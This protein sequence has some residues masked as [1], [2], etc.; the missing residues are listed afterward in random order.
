M[1][2]DF[3]LVRWGDGRTQFHQTRINSR[4]KKY[5][6]QFTLTRGDTVLVP[7][8][9]K[10]LDMLMLQEQGFNVV[11]VELS[12]V[13]AKAF[14]NE[15]QLSY[16]VSKNGN[17]QEFTGTGNAIG[18]RLLVGDFFDV[19]AAEI[20]AISAFYDRA[21]LIAL[22]PEMRRQYAVK[23]AEL[24]PAGASGLLISLT[25]DPSKM[26]GP[27]F[28]VPHEEVVELFSARFNITE[29]ENYS[30][31]ERLGSLAQR[32]LDTM[33]ERVYQLERNESLA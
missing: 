25:Y 18:I 24:V 21:S 23:M 6:P 16:E 10:S 29:L 26:N 11:G 27:P 15:N 2:A 31:H 14:F 7:L 33:E 3:W 9:G 4:L 19:E 22:P 8:C 32:G 13:A 28:S 1:D 12:D 17:F 20:G 30:G 5:W